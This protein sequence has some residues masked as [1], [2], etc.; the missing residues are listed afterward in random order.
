M[1]RPDREA[2]RLLEER[3]REVD[4]RLRRRITEVAQLLDVHPAARQAFVTACA[5]AAHLHS[6]DC[7]LVDHEFRSGRSSPAEDEATREAVAEREWDQSL[8][9]L[10][11][12][13]ERAR[14]AA[15]AEEPPEEPDRHY[16]VRYRP[17]SGLTRPLDD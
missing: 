2:H 4:R 3:H 1:T 11:T 14:E 15:L 5:R 12:A 10:R 8:G 7:A 16:E 6:A 9:Q 17:I 13:L